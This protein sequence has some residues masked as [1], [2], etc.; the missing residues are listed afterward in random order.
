MREN[1][2]FLLKTLDNQVK[3]Y[4]YSLYDRTEKE[5]CSMMNIWIVNFLCEHPDRDIFQKDIEL[6]F[7]INRATAS[8][9]LTLME[10]K[11]WI[12]RESV[13]HDAR[14]K[15]LVL[16]PKAYALHK[17]GLEVRARIDQKLEWSLSEEEKA[18]FITLCKKIIQGMS[19]M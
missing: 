16:Q 14:L 6:E 8:K 11:G 10:Q 5:A 1:I 12:C 13:S 7:S 2:G 15:K 3:R 4:A 17:K 19:H 9:M 18:Q